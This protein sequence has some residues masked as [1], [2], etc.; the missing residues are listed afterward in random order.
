MLNVWLTNRTF[1][2]TDLNYNGSS[3]VHDTRLLP[4]WSE[5]ASSGTSTITTQN[6]YTYLK[7]VLGTPSGGDAWA[8]VADRTAVDASFVDGSMPAIA[9]G[10]TSYSTTGG[11]NAYGDYD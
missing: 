9:A 2:I 1:S 10:S 3:T 8:D 11:V 6:S 4:K 5:V 7:A